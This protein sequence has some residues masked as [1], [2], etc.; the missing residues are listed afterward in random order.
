MKQI[1]YL[2]S[3]LRSGAISH[4]EHPRNGLKRT[5]FFLGMA[6]MGRPTKGNWD[7]VQLH[8]RYKVEIGFYFRNGGSMSLHRF[9]NYEVYL[10][11]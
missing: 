7:E 6:E 4:V 2:Q 1:L 8:L 11:S 3:E 10:E 5:V 9:N